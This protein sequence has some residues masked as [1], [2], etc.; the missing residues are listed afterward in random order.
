MN[1]PHWLASRRWQLA[2]EVALLALAC[3][4]AAH[5]INFTPYGW[6][7]P[8]GDVKE[9]RAYALAFWTV[10]PLLH[11]LPLEY[12]PLAIFPFTLTLLPPLHDPVVVFGWWMS[13][14]VIAGYLWM[15][16]YGSRARAVTYAAYLLVAANST[17]LSRFDLFPALATLLALWAAQRRRF[18]WS[19]MLLA[20]GTLLKLYP[21]FLVPLVAIEQYRALRT[22]TD[23]STSAPVRSGLR[24]GI[25]KG[26][27]LRDQ[28]QAVWQAFVAEARQPAVW[29]VAQGLSVC[30][31]V[32]LVV[33]GLAYLVAPGQALSDFTYASARPLQI[34]S[35]PASVLWLAHLFGVPASDVYSYQ[36]L[37]YIGP[38]DAVLKPLSAVALALGCLFVYWRQLRGRLEIG[39]AFIACLC[40]VLVTN[41]IFSPQY[42]I[43]ILPLVAYVDGLDPLWL[44]IG[45]LTTIIYPFIYFD[46][47]HIKYVAADWRF[48][49]T[50]ALRNALLLVVTIRAV[51]GRPATRG[52]AKPDALGKGQ[53][54]SSM[55][56]V[57]AGISGS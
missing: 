27:S 48:L 34:E 37:N 4:A 26:A 11:H 31:G 47:T 52:N 50:I 10:P 16:Y 55:N 25:G 9:Y 18:A 54:G 5:V 40:V 53:S 42:L 6:R 32:V 2:G 38:L 56:Q 44:M 20:V 13:L 33:F 46:H 39:R 17:V 49:P 15:R 41:K 51:L 1:R 12:P 3:W 19:Y 7:V 23:A 8:N 57:P 45:V 35:T 29:Q 21:A 43:W 24:K 28:A 14:L 30:A 36:S 22:P